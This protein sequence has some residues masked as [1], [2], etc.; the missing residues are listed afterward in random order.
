MDGGTDKENRRVE[1][2]GV[3]TVVGQNVAPPAEV[4]GAPHTPILIS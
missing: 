4:D 2:Y 1:I 3:R